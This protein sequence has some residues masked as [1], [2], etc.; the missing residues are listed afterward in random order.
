MQGGV[1]GQALELDRIQFERTAGKATHQAGS[2]RDRGGRLKLSWPD[3]VHGCH[4]AAAASAWPA[5]SA[6]GMLVR[7]RAPA[8]TGEAPSQSSTM[9][10]QPKRAARAAAC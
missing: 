3:V 2:S 8:G 6:S 7:T 5:S 1:F 9:V 10:E 4:Q